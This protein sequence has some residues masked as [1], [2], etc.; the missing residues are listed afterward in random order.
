MEY[1]CAATS[2]TGF[3]QQLAVNYVTHGYWRY[4]T[5]MLPESKDIA[6]IDA[7]LVDKYGIDISPWSRARRKKR[8][9]A[10]LQYIRHDRFFVLV[11]TEG[12]HPAFLR[13]EGAVLRDARE[14][15]ICYA[16]YAIGYRGGHAS[17]RIEQGELKRLRAYFLDVAVHRRAATL[18]QELRALPFVGYA[19]IR[20]QLYGLFLAV[21]KRRQAMGYDPVPHGALN[22]ERPIVF[23]FGEPDRTPGRGLAIAQRPVEG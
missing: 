2:V 9:L 15:P 22:F 12:A 23:P 6:R 17:V 11:A 4:V 1:R 14:V 20:S 18:A 3:V 13:E 8:G 19:P 21:N 10:N 7:K 16:G 5:G